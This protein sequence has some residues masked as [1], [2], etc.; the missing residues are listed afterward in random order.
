MQL[1]FSADD[2]G[3]TRI[4]ATA[5]P[6]LE[7]RF[8]LRMLR[9]RPHPLF[10]KWRDSLPHRLDLRP[11]AYAQTALTP[12]WGRIETL[13]G[14]DRARRSKAVLDGGV[15][16]LLSTLHPA[17]RW[18]PPVLEVIPAEGGPSTIALNGRGLLLQPSVFL[19]DGPVVEDGDVPTLVYPVSYEVGDPCT[20]DGLI[21]LIGR[22]RAVMMQVMQ[23]AGATSSDLSRKTGLTAAAVSQHLDVLRRS[24]MVVTQALGRSRLHSLT[25]AGLRLVQSSLLEHR[26]R[27][28]PPNHPVRLPLDPVLSPP[29]PGLSPL[30][31]VLSPLDPV[32]SPLDPGWSPLPSPD[33]V[34]IPDRAPR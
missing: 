11:E 30:D 16:A 23:R 5:D 2:L 12:W 31:P 25:P 34:S 17:V 18:R 15:D 13:I 14:A 26:R 33:E 3:R 9:G 22:T 8:S 24:G 27:I 29:D 20:P 10:T 6:A 19:W 7:M 32:L 28:P 1:I 4:A 21:A